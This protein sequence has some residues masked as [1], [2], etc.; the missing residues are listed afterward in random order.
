MAKLLIVLVLSLVL[1]AVGVV[2]LSRGLRQAQAAA[3]GAGP[4]G[5]V[6]VARR[7]VLDP[8]VWGGVALEAAF[9][10]G[11]LYMLSQ[12]DVSVIW[13]L[14]ALGFLSTTLAAKFVLGEAVTW[15]RWSGVALIVAGAAL[16]TYSEAGRPR[17]AARSAGTGS[18]AHGSSP[19]GRPPPGNPP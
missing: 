14:T 1:E 2:L 16:V 5:V 7:A 6:S 8:R 10:A 11:L 17:P 3:E 9:F 19:Q 18:S 12:R 4:A 13:P 15:V